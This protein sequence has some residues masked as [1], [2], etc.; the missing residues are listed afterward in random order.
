MLF[1]YSSSG[2]NRT[3]KKGKGLKAKIEST[4][5]MKVVFV[6]EERTKSSIICKRED[7]PLKHWVGW[8]LNYFPGPGAW[9]QQNFGKLPGIEKGRG[10]WNLPFSKRQG[11]RR[12]VS[13]HQ[14]PSYSDQTKTTGR[15]SKNLHPTNTKRYWPCS[16]GDHRSTIRGVIKSIGKY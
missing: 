15:S 5:T 13:R 11:R 1:G 10:I 3:T 7:L 2:P 4:C 8:R 6:L 16:R 14:S 12:W 9:L